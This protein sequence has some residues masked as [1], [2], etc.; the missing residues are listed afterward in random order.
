MTTIGAA[1][2]GAP[3]D[4]LVDGALD[5]EG[6]ALALASS[7]DVILRLAPPSSAPAAPPYGPLPVAP[8]E[9]RLRRGSAEAEVVSEPGRRVIL[10][11]IAVRTR[12]LAWG[13]WGGSPFTK[14]LAEATVEL[15]GAGEHRVAFGID[16]DEESARRGVTAVA[17]AL[18]RLVAGDPAE[19]R[20]APD[21]PVGRGVA[22]RLGLALEGDYVVLRDYESRGPREDVGRYVLFALASAVLGAIAWAAFVRELSGVRSL[23]GLLGYAVVGSVLAIGAFAMG[24]IARFASRYSAESAPLAWFFDD[25]VVVGPWVSRQGAVDLQ[26]EGKLGAGVRIG[27]VIDCVTVRREGATA[28]MLETRHG[29]MDVFSTTDAAL[30]EA[31]RRALTRA[32]VAVAAPAKKAV[33]IVKAARARAA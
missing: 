20:S 13:G 17:D 12:T 6:A 16:E 14:H 9:V 2:D 8:L 5:P 28:V 4:G 24:E 1:S 32:L 29:P 7:D 25:R 23:S 15:Q 33:G 26:P 11:E 18:A 19:E 21:A 22:R 27:D 31:Y 3:G 10:G 30:A